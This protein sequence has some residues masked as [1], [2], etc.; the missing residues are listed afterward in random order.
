MEVSR[1]DFDDMNLNS[2]I[3]VFNN[4]LLEKFQSDQH[5]MTPEMQT[6]ELEWSRAYQQKGFFVT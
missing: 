4:E 6:L 1:T 2:L 5:E 3:N